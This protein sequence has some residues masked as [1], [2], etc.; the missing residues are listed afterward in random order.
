MQDV[1]KHVIITEEG[2]FVQK[3]TLHPIDLNPILS[4]YANNT[5]MMITPNMRDGI[6]F[7]VTSDKVIG[8]RRLFSVPFRCHM[9]FDASV[10]KYTPRFGKTGGDN[11]FVIPADV[12][13]PEFRFV[14]PDNM[15]S[16]LLIPFTHDFHPDGE[17]YLL[18]GIV[19]GSR[20]ITEKRTWRTFHPPMP[21]IYSDGML[22]P[23]EEVAFRRS[24]LREW[25][26]HD[27]SRDFVDAFERIQEGWFSAAWNGDLLGKGITDNARLCK[28]VLQFDAKTMQNVPVPDAYEWDTLLFQ[29]VPG[30]EITATAAQMYLGDI[31]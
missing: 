20:P 25:M 26:H 28:E 5:L 2:A 7:M 19:D 16:I 14:F 9:V 8:I 21:N 22:C 11:A 6:R 23:G 17:M 3:T 13:L 30:C 4:D 12:G 27:P 10:E 1:T 18:S 29:A 24:Q 15:A 31:L